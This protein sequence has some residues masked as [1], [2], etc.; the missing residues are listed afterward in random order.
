VFQLALFTPTPKAARCM[1]KIPP[2][3]FNSHHIRDADLTCA[4]P[5]CG[6]VGRPR[7]SSH[8]PP[9]PQCTNDTGNPDRIFG[10]GIILSSSPRPTNGIRY[11]SSE[12][13]ASPAVGPVAREMVISHR[14][15]PRWSASSGCAS[16][17]ATR[18]AQFQRFFG[19]IRFASLSPKRDYRQAVRAVTSFGVSVCGALLV[20]ACIER[21]RNT[22]RP[23]VRPRPCRN[24]SM[25]RQACSLLRDPGHAR[26]QF[27]M[28]FGPDGIGHFRG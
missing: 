6:M 26:R 20:V 8:H 27:R 21:I 24:A 12:G 7:F 3:R 9:A 11:A 25:T 5:L 16:L 2:R 23:E 4:P 14:R 22:V 10:S 1:L 19:C 18:G 28:E 13:S 17:P 15:I